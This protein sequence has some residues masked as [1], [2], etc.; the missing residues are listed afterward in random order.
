MM[1][2]EQRDTQCVE[3]ERIVYD[4]RR[5]SVRS[6]VTR[7]ISSPGLNQKLQQR[8]RVDQ[9]IKTLKVASQS[10]CCAKFTTS[11]SIEIMEVQLQLDWELRTTF[12]CDMLALLIYKNVQMY[13]I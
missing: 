6:I 8:I 11:E 3:K 9:S 5:S 1:Y 4:V 12:I 13:E 2:V 7:L 10:I